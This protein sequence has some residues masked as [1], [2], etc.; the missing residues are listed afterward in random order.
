MVLYPLGY[1]LCMVAGACLASL[2]LVFVVGETCAAAI[3]FLYIL[4]S[5]REVVQN[6]VCS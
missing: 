3:D 6:L 2:G 5:D 4:P 1:R